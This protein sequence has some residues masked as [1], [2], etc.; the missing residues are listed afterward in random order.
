MTLSDLQTALFSL[1][2]ALLDDIYG[3]IHR[4]L[5]H[6]VRRRESVAIG[7]AL[8]GDGTQTC[9]ITD[10]PNRINRN[11]MNLWQEWV[12]YWLKKRNRNQSKQLS[13]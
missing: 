12:H 10:S 13:A 3:R 9:E 1:W 8:G 11:V 2:R 4:L 5:R 6:T 7:G